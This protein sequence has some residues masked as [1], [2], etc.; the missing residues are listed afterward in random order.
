[1][2]HPHISTGIPVVDAVRERGP[3][4]ISLA[5]AVTAVAMDLRRAPTPPKA[6]SRCLVQSIIVATTS[7]ALLDLYL[8]TTSSPH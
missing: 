3:P 8:L 1:M 7:F 4:D 2:P 6:V 5:V